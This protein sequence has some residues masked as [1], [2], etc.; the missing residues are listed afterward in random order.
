[1]PLVQITPRF[2]VMAQPGLDEFEALRARGAV[3]LINNRPDGEEAGQPG[4]EAERQA[5]EAAGLHY[6]HIPV[7]ADGMT[8]RDAAWMQME[9]AVLSGPVVAHCRSGARSFFLWLM[10]DEASQLSDTE[11]LALGDQ[12]GLP[13]D[14]VSA[15]ISS[16]RAAKTEGGL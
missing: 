7:T 1:M 5:A 6:A 2:W 12:L 9:L 11:I 16:H 3:K 14:K 13:R 8:E 10:T 15:R 4:T